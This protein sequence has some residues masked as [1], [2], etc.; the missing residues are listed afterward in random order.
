MNVRK[1][2]EVTFA[3]ALLKAGAP[4]GTQAMVRPSA[5]KEFG[6]Y[7]A[8]GIMAAAKALKMAP[9]D[10]ALRVVAFVDVS[11]FADTLEVAGPG[12]INI[13][14]KPSFI[15]RCA[16][17]AL[18]DARLG[19]EKVA[20]PVTVV[21]DYSSPTLA[22]EMHVGHLR[23][24]II[25]DAVGRIQKFLGHEV[26]RHN[27]VGDWGTQFGMLIAYLE[28]LKAEGNEKLGL[29][30]ADLEAFYRAA[31]LRFDT[32]PAF[33][34]TARQTVVRLQAGDAACKEHWAFF[35]EKSLEHCEEVYKRLNVLL[36][37]AD[38]KGESSYNSELAGIV[39]DL[40]AKGF[41]TESQGAQCVFLDEFKGK[42]D[43]P[44]PI[45]IRKSDGG[46]LYMT[47]DLAA[48][49]YRNKN[50]GAARLLYVI[51]AR[52]SLHLQQLFT[53]GRKAGYCEASCETEHVA[54]GMVL[55]EDGKPFKTRSGDVVKLSGLLDEAQ[56]L[57]YGLVLQKNPDMAEEELRHIAKVVGISSV[58][59]ADL[60][61]NRTSDY[62][63]S[64]AS[65]LAF[66]GNTAPYMLYA[67]AR[68]VSILRKAGAEVQGSALTAGH[69]EVL[70][71]AER[72]LALKLIQ[73]SETVF[74]AASE[75]LPHYVCTYLYEL[76]GMF[77]SFYEACP[78]LASEG[79]I[80]E[81][82]LKLA[83]LTA[84]T[85]SLGLDLL[86]LETLD[87]M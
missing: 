81:S 52:Q 60:S 47:S 73:L 30:L 35:I 71:P 10:L 82:R 18:S 46:Y 45:I 65:M 77:M 39:A 80:K 29:E 26:I 36:T 49:R 5:K 68:I 66:E 20:T 43:A 31:K 8:N 83:Q 58:K 23:S 33:A 55:G 87:R 74:A 2:L 1:F 84:R 86:G 59:Y 27:H 15:S 12:F 4:A 67:Y 72:A 62:I 25:G 34:E 70:Q 56:E 61:K 11:E 64:W 79:N 42:E 3:Q 41:V 57:A 44:L 51:D 38:V 7:Q 63:F 14:L 19:V 6:D 32:D 85:L 40:Q 78:I 21:V 13:F 17:E 28:N 22:K 54:F 50:L 37:R 76:A 16:Q 48:L 24:T 69:L 9:R 75:N 53:L